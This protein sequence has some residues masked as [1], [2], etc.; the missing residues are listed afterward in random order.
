MSQAPLARRASHALPLIMRINWF[1]PLGPFDCFIPPSFLLQ[2]YPQAEEGRPRDTRAFISFGFCLTWLCSSPTPTP[3]SAPAPTLT[4]APFFDCLSSPAPST[5]SGRSLAYFC[6][7]LIFNLPPR[8]GL[9]TWPLPPL[10]LQLSVY[11]TVCCLLPPPPHFVSVY[12][13]LSA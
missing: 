6:K 4:T 10:F 2:P 5:S 3:A 1:A 7:R 9:A 13:V 11:P 8:C 12:S